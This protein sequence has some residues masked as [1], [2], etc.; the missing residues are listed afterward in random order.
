MPFGYDPYIR[1][2]KS[3]QMYMPEI[4][5]WF[6][7][8]SFIVISV[9]KILTPP[10]QDLCLVLSFWN[11]LIPSLSSSLLLYGTIPTNAGCLLTFH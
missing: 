6:T 1:L 9:C 7:V 10:K 5:N 2:E 11:S 4:G 3:A 8:Q